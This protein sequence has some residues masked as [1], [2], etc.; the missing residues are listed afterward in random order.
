MRAASDRPEAFDERVLAALDGGALALMLSIGHRTGL[1]DVLADLPPA[2]S[3]AIASRAG[4]CEGPVRAWLGALAGVRVIDHDARAGTYHLPP[5]H[6]ASLIRAARPGNLAET[7]RWISLLGTLEDEVVD[8]FA[9]GGGLSPTAAEDFDGVL[10][11]ASDRM[12]VALLDRLIP[13]VGRGRLAGQ[14]GGIDVLDVDCGGA[15]AL[16]RMAE[17]FPECRFVGYDRSESAVYAA[18]R[19]ARSL[20]LSNACIEVRDFAAL[21]DAAR[22]DL[23]TVFGGLPE[24]DRSERILA[25]IARALRPGGTLLVQEHAGARPIQGGGG[26]GRA[27]S[28]GA[29]LSCLHGLTASLVRDGA[30]LGAAPDVE[31]PAR[32]IRRAGLEPVEHHAVLRDPLHRYT[33]ARRPLD[34]RPLYPAV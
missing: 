2:T 7:C 34:P 16:C 11:E 23:V 10:A 8:C 24:A 18:R 25:Q 19:R 5:E 20:G 17:A 6:A 21:A 9:N 33:L 26:L 31:A 15:R 3:E 28:A 1:F 27:A 32:R 4:L 12:V 14:A 22:F 30:D 13:S 29:L